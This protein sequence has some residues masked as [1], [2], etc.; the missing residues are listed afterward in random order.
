LFM[1]RAAND[2]DAARI[3]ATCPFTKYGGR[4]EVKRLE[5]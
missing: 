4:V 5:E 1:I 3:V 2:S